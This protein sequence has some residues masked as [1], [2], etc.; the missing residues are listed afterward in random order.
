MIDFI[1]SNSPHFGLWHI[2][3]FVTG[4]KCQTYQRTEGRNRQ[5]QKY[6]VFCKP[7]KRNVL[8]LMMFTMIPITIIPIILNVMIIIIT[9]ANVISDL[10]VAS[11]FKLF[12]A[13]CVIFKTPSP[14]EIFYCHLI[15][16]LYPFISF[17]SFSKRTAVEL[18][19]TWLKKRK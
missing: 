15:A 18:L 2:F 19:L 11:I 1:L 14:L 5:T 6:I 8:S 17:N 3:Y 16:P 9:L 12:L 10:V 13:F 4:S 7:G